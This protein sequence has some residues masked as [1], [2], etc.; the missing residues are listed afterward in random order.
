MSVG[1]L[2]FS[3][4]SYT[5][6]EGLGQALFEE[7]GDALFLLDP[8]SDGMLDVN[9]RAVELTGYSAKELL[10]FPATYLFRFQGKS[11][12]MQGFRKAAQESGVFHSKEGYLLRT[13]RDGVWIPVNLTIAR[14]HVKPKTVALITVRDIREQRETQAKLQRTQDRL[15][16]VLQHSPIALFAFDSLGVL[17]L[18]EGRL[19]EKGRVPIAQ[20][21]GRSLMQLYRDEPEVLRHVRRALDGERCTA[22]LAIQHGPG[23][24]RTYETHF[25]PI[26]GAKGQIKEVV[27]MFTDITQRLQTEEALREQQAVLQ[28]VVEHIPYSIFWKDREGLN[29]GCNVNFAQDCGFQSPADVRGKTDFDMPWTRE[30]AEFFLHCDHAVMNSGKP[31]LNIEETQLQAGG[32][33]ATLLTSKV[34]LRDAQGQIMGVLGIYTDI[35]ERKRIELELQKAKEEA[36]AASKAK[37]EFLA[38]VSHEIRTPMNGIL[39]MTELA[40]DTTLSREQRDYLEMVKA[41]ADSLLQVINDI[42][43]FS[44]IEAGKLELF[45]VPFELRDALGDALKTLSVR[46][47]QKRLELAFHVPADVPDLLIGDPGRLRQVIVNLVGN[48]IKF[49]EDGEVVVRVGVASPARSGTA[50]LQFEVS[51]T[52]IGIPPDKL[53]TIFDPFVQADGSTTRKYGGTGLGLAISS[54]LVEMMQGKIGVE[55]EV[56]KGSRFSFTA[57]FALQDTARRPT[58]PRELLTCE[59]MRV[60]VVDD[61]AT[62]RRILEEVLANWR[63]RPTSVDSGRAALAELQHAVERGEPFPLVLLDA[64]MPQMDGFSLAHE[65]RARPELTKSVLMMLSSAGRVEDAERCRQLGVNRYLIKPIKHS[66]LLDA[67][68]SALPDVG[69]PEPSPPATVATEPTPLPSS[70]LR[71]LVA[72]DN[73][74]NQRLILRVL[75][76]RGYLV[77][78]TGNGREA[79]ARLEREPFDLLL[80]DVQMP[81]L[82]GFETTAL[83]RSQEKTTGKHLPI[84]AMTAHAMKGDRERCLNAGMDG[85][86][87]KPVQMKELMDVVGQLTAKS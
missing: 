57:S 15:R 24:G 18:L 53:R 1:V 9:P 4:M 28:N 8:D 79:L 65:I 82:D 23:A 81:E 40:L 13:K 46:A 12:G 74:V 70:P 7:S 30:Q 55:S 11:G 63:M 58:L 68:L 50:Q 77:A 69:C 87:S 21:L 86:I 29:L 39:G 19:I 37:S 14:L 38:N 80:M 67:I 48:A 6:I 52:G 78:V 45:P 36:E 47:H 73:V 66:Q 41:S 60:L 25:N 34:P 2:E 22:I 26:S 59:G 84:I 31:L 71:V 85:Y 49:T 51:D 43:D 61:N 42:L 72:E 64:M 44:K 54:R 83:I 35:T 16:T 75:E 3:I 17:T 33:Q 20:L 27:G 56:G 10:S 62:N 5:S 76:K 32:K